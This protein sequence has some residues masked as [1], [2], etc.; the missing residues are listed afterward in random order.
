MMGLFSVLDVILDKPM[1]EALQMLKVSKSVSRA[2]I[3]REGPFAELF[4]F[5]LQYESANWTEIDRLMILKEFDADAVYAA[6]ID[7]L[8]WYRELFIK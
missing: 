1:A 3:D 2:L 5:I 4:D 7:T 6:Y 8:K